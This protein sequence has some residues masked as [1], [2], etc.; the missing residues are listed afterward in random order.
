MS[1]QINH[2]GPQAWLLMRVLCCPSHGRMWKGK[3]ASTGRREGG[4]KESHIIITCSFY[5]KPILWWGKQTEAPRPLPLVLWFTG[6]TQSIQ[7]CAK[8]TNSFLL[9]SMQARTCQIKSCRRQG[10]SRSQVEF[11]LSAWGQ[12]ASLTGYINMFTKQEVPLSFISQLLVES[13]IGWL[14]GTRHIPSGWGWEC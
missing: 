8:L 4:Y 13:T 14:I 3:G 5:T 10:L 12:G 9:G 6:V 7:E 11:P 2:F 1:P